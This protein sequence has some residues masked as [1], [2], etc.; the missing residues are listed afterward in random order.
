MLGAITLIAVVGGSAMA[1]FAAR[2]PAHTEMLET[3]A[4]ALLIGGLALAGSSL[5]TLL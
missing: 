3:C 1:Y 4:G 5:P 2:F